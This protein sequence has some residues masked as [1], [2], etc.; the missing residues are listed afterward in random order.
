MSQGQK[1]S[2]LADLGAKGQILNQQ[3]ASLSGNVKATLDNYM[4]LTIEPLSE[5]QAPDINTLQKFDSKPDCRIISDLLNET[6]GKYM[7][8]YA[9]LYGQVRFELNA[10]FQGQ[11]S[12]E[13]QGELPLTISKVFGISEA[14]IK[15]FQAGASFYITRSPGDLPVA[16]VP[17]EYNLEELARITYYMQGE[18]GRD[19]ENAVHDAISTEDPNVFT[20]A[21]NY[22]RDIF[23]KD[24]Q[25]EYRQQWAERFFSGKTMVT[26]DQLR[27]Q[28][29]KS[30][31]FDKI[32]AYRAAQYLSGS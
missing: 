28:S 22:I 17:A 9:V 16:L 31:D 6:I 32:G 30:V 5:S 20:K 23:V 24:G 7:I 18:R 11:A 14:N 26:L 27:E 25:D 2:L 1:I 10:N 21:V 8:A 4:L 3:V 12:V 29:I 19:L 13:A 15:L